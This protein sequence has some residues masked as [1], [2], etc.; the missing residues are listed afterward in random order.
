MTR[1]VAICVAALAFAGPA[2]ADPG[3]TALYPETVPGAGLGGVAGATYTIV[4]HA[5]GQGTVGSVP[6][7]LS[8]ARVVYGRFHSTR[9][10][11]TL[12]ALNAVKVRGTGTIDGHTVAFTAV[13]VH[14]ALPGVDIFRIA[15]DHGASFG[16]RVTTGTVFIR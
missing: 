9:V 12:W 6:F 3:Y 2:A 16:G 5:S 10:R 4:R 7:S 8:T 15:W 1:L 14:N 13:G 11:S